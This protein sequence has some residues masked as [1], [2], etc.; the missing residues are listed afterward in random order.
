FSL[1]LMLLF[2]SLP[3]AA[4]NN[5]NVK[6]A[7]K[8]VIF[9]NMSELLFSKLNLFNHIYNGTTSIK[10]RNLALIYRV[11]S[12]QSIILI[13]S[14]WH[15][16]FHILCYIFFINHFIR[17]FFFTFCGTSFLSIISY[18]FTLSFRTFSFTVV[19]VLS[20]FSI[21]KVLALAWPCSSTV[22]IVFVT[23]LLVYGIVSSGKD[24]YS[25]NV[26]ESLY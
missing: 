15:F 16:L 9:F 1:F 20:P 14:L 3:Q 12:M 6:R 25:N 2:P 18:A 21:V 8:T 10:P 24:T 5:K 11:N 17:F 13:N 22:G 23:F 7:I 26:L 4:S 19:F